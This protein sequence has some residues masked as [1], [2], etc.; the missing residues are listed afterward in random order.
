MCVCVWRVCASECTYA[1]AVS[2][3]WRLGTQTSPASAGDLHLATPHD[4]QIFGPL[5][6]LIAQCLLGIRTLPC[7]QETLCIWAPGMG[8]TK[9]DLL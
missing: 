8:I 5:S 4:L 9:L 2:R 6:C 3:P 7:K 1:T